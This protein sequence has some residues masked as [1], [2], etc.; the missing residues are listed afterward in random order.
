MNELPNKITRIDVVRVERG[1]EKLCKCRKPHYEIDTQNHIV[2]CL[3]C[4]AIVDP[5]V[6]ITQ[7]ATD[8][9]RLNSQVKTILEQAREIQNYKP[10]L[11]VIKEI[12]H[13]Y[14]ANK[15]S[16]VPCCP[17]CGEPFDLAEINSWA[18]RRMF[19]HRERETK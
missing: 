18:S 19:L 3:D 1:K 10:H 2:M 13:R 14:R 8:C 11:R 12:E 7:I 17:R 5:F 4:G 15:F 16:M 9:D 6:A